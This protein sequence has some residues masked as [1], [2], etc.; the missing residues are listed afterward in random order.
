MPSMQVDLV[1]RF[2]VNGLLYE[3]VG[4][5]DNDGGF[6]GWKPGVIVELK[7]VTG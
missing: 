6:H 1:D 2:V 7:R 5:R 4:T 3:V